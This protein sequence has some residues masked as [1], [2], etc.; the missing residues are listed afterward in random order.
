MLAVLA[1][2]TVLAVLAVLAV[3]TGIVSGRSRSRHEGAAVPPR[4]VIG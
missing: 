1:V 3:P 4:R 2:P